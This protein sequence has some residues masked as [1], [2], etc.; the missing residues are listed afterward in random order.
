[1]ADLDLSMPEFKVPGIPGYTP[2]FGTKKPDGESLTTEEV[3]KNME[4]L[5][6]GDVQT[7]NIDKEATSATYNI[8][9][10]VS[11]VVFLKP[12]FF[13]SGLGSLTLTIGKAREGAKI[14]I[15][16]HSI[17]SVTLKIDL[18]SN[19]TNTVY[20]LNGLESWLVIYIG[21]TFTVQP[22]SATNNN[23]HL[24]YY[25]EKLATQVAVAGCALGKNLGDLFNSEDFG[26]FLSAVHGFSQ[27]KNHNMQ[28]GDY[29][30]IP[31][32]TLEGTT[33]SGRNSNHTLRIVISG[34]NMFSR[35]NNLGFSGQFLWTFQNVVFQKLIRQDGTNDGYEDSYLNSFLNTA[36]FQAL[37]AAS[38]NSPWFFQTKRLV[39]RKNHFTTKSCSVFL[40]CEQEVFGRQIY[41]DDHLNTNPGI[42]FPIY[43]N[44]KYF[45]VKTYNGTPSSWWTSSPRT[46]TGT[47]FSSV[48]PNGDPDCTASNT[49]TMGVSPAFCTY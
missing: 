19:H 5:G 20:N 18:T 15:D 38:N 35:F 10:L 40:P 2:P 11:D 7:I 48:D 44:S 49:I 13:S 24:R 8:P 30:D 46:D 43:R 36:F 9:N 39:S 47:Y 45:R 12:Q 29:Y 4:L 28:I 23:E 37:F 25:S 32:L 33:I 41:G 26:D 3:I 34:Y 22:V 16:V 6:A 14:L 17:N 31:S 21:G 42:Q 1:M 27:D